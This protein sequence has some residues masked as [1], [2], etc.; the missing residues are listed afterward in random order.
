MASWQSPQTR[1]WMISTGV[2]WHTHFWESWD[3]S[4]SQPWPADFSV[5][6]LSCCYCC[7]CCLEICV[8]FF[9]LITKFLLWFFYGNKDYLGIPWLFHLHPSTL[10]FL[11]GTPS[12]RF[13]TYLI[14]SWY[15]LPLGNKSIKDPSSQDSNY[16]VIAPAES[17][18]SLKESSDHKSQCIWKFMIPYQEVPK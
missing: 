12:Y 7:C 15:L 14:I 8:S 18:T 16:L 10:G 2:L 17:F 4:V 6:L 11:M 1:A 9:H 3:P 5:T 13:F